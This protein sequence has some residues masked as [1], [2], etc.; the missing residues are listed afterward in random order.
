MILSV[1]VRIKW[2]VTSGPGDGD[3]DVDHQFQ[4]GTTS[5]GVP[6]RGRRRSK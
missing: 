3:K 2:S 6:D 4:I 5:S 1:S